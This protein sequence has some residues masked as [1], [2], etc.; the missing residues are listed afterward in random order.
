M[1]KKWFRS[2]ILWA[3]VIGIAVIIVSTVCA[4]EEL[5]QAILTAE[6]SILA[7]INLALRLITNQGLE[8]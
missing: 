5:A 4:N 8:K 2:R 1:K 6:G 7:I 3:N